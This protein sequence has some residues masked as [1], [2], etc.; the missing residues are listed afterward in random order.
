MVQKAGYPIEVARFITLFS[1]FYH[2][3]NGE[4]FLA[5]CLDWMDL[6]IKQCLGIWGVE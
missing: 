1:G 6:L 4:F 5:G 2:H 3:P